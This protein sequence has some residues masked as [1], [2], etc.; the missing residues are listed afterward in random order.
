MPYRVTL[1]FN[2]D[3]ENKP[4]SSEAVDHY[5]SN[6]VNKVSPGQVLA[7]LHPLAAE[8]SDSPAESD[9]TDIFTI[10]NKADIISPA[11]EL[12][13]NNGQLEVISKKN[14][15][16]ALVNQQI[17]V[18]QHLTI[19]GDINFHTGN[20]N[21]PGNLLI[22]GS[23]MAG[24]KVKAE[25][26]TVIGSIEN[27]EVECRGN[28]V[29]AGGIVACQDYPLL[30]GANLWCKY[31]ENSRIEVKNNIFI[32][33]SSLHSFLK[34]GNNIVLCHNSAVLVGGKSEAGNSLYSGAL[35]AKWATPTEVV[36]GCEPFLAKNLEDHCRQ[37]EK[38]ETEL[39]ALKE[40]VDQINTFLQHEEGKTTRHDAHRLQEE[41][42]LLESKLSF[43]IHKHKT[44]LSKHN[45][46]ENQ[47]AEFKMAN[48]DCILHVSKQL[49]S[50]IRLTIKD[51]ETRIEEE[52]SSIPIIML[53]QNGEIVTTPSTVM[54]S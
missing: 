45:E 24:F 7:Q 48:A 46:L 54:H 32:S 39:D 30:C 38:L 47:I 42:E 35:G 3:P 37:F 13:E 18:H 1:R 41:R 17:F 43:V 11:V 12:S 21:C 26:L 20:I 6:V 25:N 53:E 49:F 10:R 40:R 9:S 33:G 51:A 34:A 29:C 50:G 27:A 31:L 5:R 14:G 16:P 15:F 22:K 2:K 36:L 4:D 52:S 44:A 23:I 8:E 28:L 19:D